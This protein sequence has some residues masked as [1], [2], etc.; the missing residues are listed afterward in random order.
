MHSVYLIRGW[1]ILK[2]SLWCHQQRMQEASVSLLCR[3]YAHL[4]SAEATCYHLAAGNK[5]H[6]WNAILRLPAGWQ[7]S[8]C[9]ADEPSAP[10][11]AKHPNRLFYS[12]Q[13]KF[14][15]FHLSRPDVRVGRNSHNKQRRWIHQRFFSSEFPTRF[16]LSVSGWFVFWYLTW[17]GW[18]PYFLLCW[19]QTCSRASAG[20]C[21]L[22]VPRLCRVWWTRRTRRGR[23]RPVTSASPFTCG[24]CPFPHLSWDKS[25]SG[26]SN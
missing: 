2:V 13:S 19:M 20:S 8:E 14:R 7:Q 15:V 24:S 23:T 4:H 25:K 11:R 16:S 6:P 26:C 3:I 12:D 5:D 10:K 18:F 17:A 21:S 22:L 9:F 1:I